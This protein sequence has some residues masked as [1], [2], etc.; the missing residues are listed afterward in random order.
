[1]STTDTQAPDLTTYPA[2]SAGAT[3]R[4]ALLMLDHCE[5]RDTDEDVARAMYLLRTA[6]QQIDALAG[7]I[8]EYTTHV[9]HARAV[10]ERG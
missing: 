5:S 2:I 10:A 9:G 8:D 3:V 1:M 4:G 6:I 7:E